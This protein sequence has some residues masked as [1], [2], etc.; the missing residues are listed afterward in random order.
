REAV[1]E[2]RQ[3]LLHGRIS[4]ATLDMESGKVFFDADQMVDDDD[5]TDPGTRPSSW[6]PQKRDGQWVEGTVALDQ[7]PPEPPSRMPIYIGAA[8]VAVALAGGAWYY[9]S[10]P[11]ELSGVVQL[12]I[13]TRNELA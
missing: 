6:P 3:A 10:K 1:M 5:G 13:E 8:V 12:L 4:E 9:F 11:K 2:S 7:A